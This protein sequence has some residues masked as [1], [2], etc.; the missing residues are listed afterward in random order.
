MKRSCH[1]P[2]RHGQRT[3]SSESA[4]VEPG[5][6][7]SA[8]CRV[9]LPHASLQVASR[10]SSRTTKGAKSTNLLYYCTGLHHAGR[11]A[12]LYP[13]RRIQTWSHLYVRTD[14]GLHY[15]RCLAQDWFRQPGAVSVPVQA[16]ALVT[17]VARFVRHPRSYSCA[18]LEQPH[19]AAVLDVD[20]LH[21]ARF[22]IPDYSA[23]RTKQD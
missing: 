6:Q 12:G 11:D 16:V 13:V 19:L 4:T 7:T 14:R 5:R 8:S 23:V 2:P 18:S 21:I 17:T 15:G 9:T 10:A 20:D 1:D 3:R 22:P